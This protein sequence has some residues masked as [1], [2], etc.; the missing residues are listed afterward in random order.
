MLQFNQIFM[1]IKHFRISSSLTA[2]LFIFLLLRGEIMFQFSSELNLRCNQQQ[3]NC[4]IIP[5]FF[6]IK[7]KKQNVEVF[8]TVFL[9]FRRD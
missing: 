1:N 4:F 9:E 3:I 5:R 6:D 8:E 7:T 2:K